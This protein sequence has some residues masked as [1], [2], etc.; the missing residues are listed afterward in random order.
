MSPLFSPR[1]H[2][3]SPPAPKIQ[4]TCIPDKC[5][6]A[7]QRRSSALLPGCDA[8]VGFASQLELLILLS[9]VSLSLSGTLS[10]SGIRPRSDPAYLHPQAD[11]LKKKNKQKKNP[12]ARTHSPTHIH[13]H[14][15]PSPLCDITALLGDLIKH[16]HRQ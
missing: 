14:Q 9:A 3:P 5:C 16:R 1:T 12:T 7:K 8:A 11:T 4:P 2:P 6:A 10:L 13:T 15:I